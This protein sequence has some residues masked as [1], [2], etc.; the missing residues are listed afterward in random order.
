MMKLDVYVPHILEWMNVEP[1]RLT[2]ESC[3]YWFVFGPR[4]VVALPL[5]QEVARILGL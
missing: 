3:E 5:T 1:W 4:D 2:V